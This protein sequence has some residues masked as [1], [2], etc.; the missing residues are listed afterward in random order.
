MR[1]CKGNYLGPHGSSLIANLLWQYLYQPHT[2]LFDPFELDR[3][4]L[5]DSLR[6]ADRRLG[7]SSS[8][9]GQ[10]DPMLVMQ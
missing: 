7:P 1:H 5:T 3:W 2:K 4:E 9:Y 6:A 8:F 10:P